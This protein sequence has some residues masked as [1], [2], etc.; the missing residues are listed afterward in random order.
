[1][2]LTMGLPRQKPGRLIRLAW[3][4]RGLTKIPDSR[5]NR[6][7]TASS[8]YRP[9]WIVTL[10]VVSSVVL[11]GCDPNR[12]RIGIT[13]HPSNRAKGQLYGN[14]LY[15]RETRYINGEMNYGITAKVTV[16]NIGETGFLKVIVN[17]R[18]SEGEWNHVEEISLCAGKYRTLTHF[19][20]EPTHNA[21]NVQLRGIVSP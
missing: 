10:M 14:V 20:P 2:D 9:G 8:S 1:M 21:I 7:A 18:C 15:N 12:G 11:S 17:L 16:R 6:G 4:D 19:F 5:L 3:R 13:E